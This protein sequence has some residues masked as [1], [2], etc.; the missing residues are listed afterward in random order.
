MRLKAMLTVNKTEFLKS[1]AVIVCCNQ[2]IDVCH[3]G[4]DTDTEI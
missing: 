1:D 2:S 4:T 3:P